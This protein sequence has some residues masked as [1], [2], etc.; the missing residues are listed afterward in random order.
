MCGGC[1]FLV[2]SNDIYNSSYRELAV[3]HS[4][5]VTGGRHFYDLYFQMRGQRD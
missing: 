3:C 4:L 1:V 2:F 5:T